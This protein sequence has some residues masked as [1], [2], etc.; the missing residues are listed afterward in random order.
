MRKPLEVTITIDTVFSIGGAFNDPSKRP[1]AEPIALCEIDGKG[2]GVDFL[3]DTFNQYDIK[4]TFFVE[5]LNYYYFGD[6]PM[7]SIVEKIQSAGQDPQLHIHPSWLKYYKDDDFTTWETNDSCA[8]RDYQELKKIFEY[9]IEIFE[10]WV[11]K[12]P[13]AIRTGNLEADINNYKDMSELKI[14][15]ASN[16]GL[17]VWKPDDGELWLESG[18]TKIFDVMEVPIFTYQDKDLMG[19]VPAKSLQIT[20]CSWPEMKYLLLKARKKGIENIVI[21]T[22]PFEFI[23]KKDIHYSQIIRNRV[24]QERLEK[25]CSF[26]KEHDQDFTSADFGSNVKEWGS[27]PLKNT[28]YFKVPPR[29]RLGRKLHN[30]VNDMIWTY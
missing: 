17:G 12:R 27:K 30:F 26:I 23:K 11:G 20:S 5:C 15:I 10:R 13:D 7:K 25:L 1:V 28:P 18:R 4:A 3:L 22:H 2:H 8:G 6:Q 19:Q 16:I 29:F 24:N 9:S 14:P 21:L